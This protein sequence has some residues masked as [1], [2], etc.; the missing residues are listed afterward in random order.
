MRVHDVMTTEVATTRPEAALKDV[1]AEL[2]Q[3]GI[4]GMPVIDDDGSVLGV[5]SEADVLAK[6]LPEKEDGGGALA[7]FRRRDDGETRRLEADLVQEVMTAPAI[8]IE[9]HWPV[10]EA[11]ERMLNGRINRLPVVRQGRIVGLVSR[12]DVVRAFARSDDEVRADVREL[13]ALQQEL[14]RDER[15]LRIEVQHGEVSLAGEARTRGEAEI[16][17]KMVRTV[18]GV[19]S[20][21]SEL[22]WAETD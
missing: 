18:P 22:T 21:R 8:T 7:R 10:A 17:A 3:R 16:V 11:A 6:S 20:V 13:V 19:V 1:A 2:V 12:A 4:S 15:P 9:E 14:L 5:V